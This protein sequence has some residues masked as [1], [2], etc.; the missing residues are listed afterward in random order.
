MLSR[1]IGTA[2][3]YRCP[4]IINPTSQDIQCHR[5][6]PVPRINLLPVSVYCAATIPYDE[7]FH[8]FIILTMPLSSVVH[9]KPLHTRKLTLQGYLRE[10]GL[11]DIEGHLIDT[12]PFDIPNRDR[13]GRIRAGES[14]HEMRVRL[15]LD[16]DFKILDAQAVTEYAPYDHCKGGPL[17]FSR[18]IGEQIG[19]GWNKRVKSILGGRQGCTHITEM[20]GQMATTAFQTLNSLQ[21]PGEPA[22]DKEEKPLILDTCLAL[23]SDS[24]VVEREW[25][26][27]YRPRD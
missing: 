12:K 26:E 18:L 14:L 23:A 11:L 6:S 4:T 2:R 22:K 24:P 10:D 3:S 9:R 5:I 21:S 20:L 13:G 8:S 19:P 27:F 17:S 1:N 16:L 15:T 7:V 25:P